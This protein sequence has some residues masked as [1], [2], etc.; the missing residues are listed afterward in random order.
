MGAEAAPRSAHD[1][2]V[3]SAARARA[4]AILTTGANVRAEP[5][6]RHEPFGA[7]AQGLN[8]WR[9]QRITRGEDIPPHTVV[10]TRDTSLDLAHPLLSGDDAATAAYVLTDRAAALSLRR[11]RHDTAA[12]PNHQAMP[13]IV[14]MHGRAA[15][16]PVSPIV[17]ARSLPLIGDVLLEC[18]VSTARPLYD[19]GAVDGLLLSVYRGSLDKSAQGKSFLS[20]GELQNYF[21]M[22]ELGKG[23]AQQYCVHAQVPS[24]SVQAVQTDQPDGTVAACWSFLR[25]LPRL[26]AG[27]SPRSV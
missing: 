8:K 26:R 27:Y 19:M 2:F 12:Q 1:A 20:W 14:E 13:H 18:G 22:E 6:L 4:G 9:R 15:V 7:G 16:N 24:Q 25:F 21:G 23:A 10:L 3:L 17:F 5:L 11:Q